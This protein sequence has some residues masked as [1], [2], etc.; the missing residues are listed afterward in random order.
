ML[1]VYDL[2]LITEGLVCSDQIYRLIKDIH[3]QHANPRTQRTYTSALKAYDVRRCCSLCCLMLAFV[4]EV[5]N[6]TAQQSCRQSSHV[7]RCLHQ[8]S[9][10]YL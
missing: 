10:A 6:M 1:F 3:R 9:P 4:A 2:P 5:G 7:C 8:Q